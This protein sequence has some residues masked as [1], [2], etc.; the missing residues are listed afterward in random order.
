[1]KYLI[2]FLKFEIHTT[3]AVFGCAKVT[4]SRDGAREFFVI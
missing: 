3:F 2:N 1:M 4:C